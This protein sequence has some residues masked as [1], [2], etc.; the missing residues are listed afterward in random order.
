MGPSYIDDNGEVQ[1]GWKTPHNHNTLA[2]A[3]A[4][5]LH[6]RDQSLTQQHFRDEQDINNIV[7]RFLK[8][9]QLPDIPVPG[10][11]ADLTTQEDYHT[12]CTKLAETNG[13]FYR[14][15]AE[16]RAI[17]A[18]DPGAW[19]QDVNERLA[20]GDL[21]PLRAM[22]LDVPEPKQDFPETPT[23]ETPAP[24]TPAGAAAPTAPNAA[25]HAAATGA[26]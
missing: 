5:A 22:G 18:N 15:A 6:C 21:E 2:E 9:G 1:Y 8:T 13:L 17:Y 7:G 20:R 12:L 25:A 19:L 23:K 14:L 3:N 4:T 26:K 10:Q 11:Y 16:T 24:G